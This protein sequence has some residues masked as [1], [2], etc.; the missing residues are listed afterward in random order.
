MLV[1]ISK[2]IKKFKKIQKNE[3][4]A[5]W[6]LAVTSQCRIEARERVFCSAAEDALGVGSRAFV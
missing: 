3:R 5:V 1:P 2:K 6:T 4:K